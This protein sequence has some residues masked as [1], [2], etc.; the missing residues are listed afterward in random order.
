L[1]SNLVWRG[2]TRP[3]RRS[4][5]ILM[6]AVTRAKTHTMM[7]QQIWPSCPIMDAFNLGSAYDLK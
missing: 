6:V 7:V 4:R 3:Y 1:V 2:D 5:K